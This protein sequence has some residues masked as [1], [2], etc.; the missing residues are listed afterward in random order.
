MYTG[1]YKVYTRWMYICVNPISYASCGKSSNP[2]VVLCSKVISCDFVMSNVDR[3]FCADKTVVNAPVMSLM[4]VYQMSL[5]I[6]ILIVSENKSYFLFKI[7][8]VVLVVKT[9]IFYK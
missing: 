6:F 8:T 7:M 3:K 1:I 9:A 5:L 4:F 2:K